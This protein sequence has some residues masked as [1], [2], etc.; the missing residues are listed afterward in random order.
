MAVHWMVPYKVYV[1]V[2]DPRYTKET[3]SPKVSKQCVTYILVYIIYYRIQFI[4]K[5]I[6][7]MHSLKKNLTETCIPLLCNYYCFWHKRGKKKAFINFYQIL[8][9]FLAKCSSSYWWVMK[10]KAFSFLN[11]DQIPKI[12]I[13]KGYIELF[14]QVYSFLLLFLNKLC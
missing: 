14:I 1:S 4:L 3:R 2:V 6:F 12:R 13:F 8:I 10:K 5:R 9:Q 7:L 11:G